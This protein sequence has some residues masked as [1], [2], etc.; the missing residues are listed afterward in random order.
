F[1]AVYVVFGMAVRPFIESYYVGG[2]LGLRIPGWGELLAVLTLRSGLF[3]VACVPVLIAW[4]GS[5]RRL[6][7][8]LGLALFVLVG[9]FQ[10]LQS[11][12]LPGTM[13]IAHALEILADSLAYLALLVVLLRPGR[14]V[15]GRTGPATRRASP[16][17]LH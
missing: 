6:I 17:P 16:I 5:S 13:R 11:Y 4:R 9:G 14:A 1:P 15:P 10:M 12:W 3:L 8:A 2:E 7:A